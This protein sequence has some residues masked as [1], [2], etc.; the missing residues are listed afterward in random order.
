LTNRERTIDIRL[1]CGNTAAL[2][3]MLMWHKD[4]PVESAA[5]QLIN[6]LFSVPQ[7]SVLLRTLPPAHLVMV[8]F[9]LAFWREHRDVLL[10]GKLMPLHPETF[11]PLVLATTPWKRVAVMYQD[12]VVNPGTQLPDTV[13]IVNGTLEKRI[14]LELTELSI[15][16]CIVWPYPLP[17]YWCC[18]APA[19]N[20]QGLFLTP[21]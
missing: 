9:W 12:T 17:E 3:D 21:P 7:I 10:D 6:I 8:H 16:D 15:R 2:A 14:I 13:L 1:L 18:N 20:K 4:E 5:L 19:A 11:Y